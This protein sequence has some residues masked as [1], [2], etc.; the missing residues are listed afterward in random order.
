MA[1]IR[2]EILIESRPEDVWEAVR[3]F[4][5]VHQRLVPGFVVD[6]RLDGDARIVTFANGMVA[7]ELLVDIDEETRRLVYAIVEGRPT[8]YNGAVQV[9]T[10]DDGHSRLV[11]IVDLLPNDLAGPIG[12]MM[13]QGAAVMKHTLEGRTA[14]C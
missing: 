11:W 1:S 4:G 2:K 7:R 9:F 12:S 8:H 13:E 14:Q 5:A 6:S 3:D 10:E